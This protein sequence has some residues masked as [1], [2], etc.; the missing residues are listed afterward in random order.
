MGDFIGISGV[1]RT[2]EKEL[3]GI[4]G[5][6]YVLVDSKSRSQ[7]R[8][9]SGEFDTA[10]VAGKKINLTI[11]QKLARIWRNFNEK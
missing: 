6:R 11:D 1:E 9:K 2:Y 3:G 8:Y 5:V 10:A 7:G 4:K